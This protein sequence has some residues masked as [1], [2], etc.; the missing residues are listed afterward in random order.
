MTLTIKLQL[1]N[2]KGAEEDLKR[3]AILKGMGN[4]CESMPLEAG[5]STYHLA[6]ALQKLGR[7]ADANIH[8]KCAIDSGYEPTYELLLTPRYPTIQ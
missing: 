3:A 1:R 2:Y 7:E 4:A 5:E 8:F 6:S